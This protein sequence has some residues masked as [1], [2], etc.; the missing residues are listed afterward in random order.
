L[1]VVTLQGSP[2]TIV[3]CPKQGGEVDVAASTGSQ[4]TG[5]LQ[6]PRSDVLCSGDTC[7]MNNCGGHGTCNNVDGTCV[8]LPGFYGSTNY[9]CD[10]L[11]CPTAVG[12]TECSGN[13]KCNDNTGVCEDNQ[14]LAGCYVGWK[15]LACAVR[16]CPSFLSPACLDPTLPCE[17]SNRGAC[18]NGTCACA[19]GFVGSGCQYT[20][21]PFNAGDR[22]SANISQGECDINTGVC[23]CGDLTAGGS[24]VEAYFGGSS[25]QRVINGTRPVTE[26]HFIGE[27]NTSATS[28]SSQVYHAYSGVLFAKETVFFSLLIPNADF[29]VE[30]R[31]QSNNSAASMRLVASYQESGRPTPSFGDF[32]ASSTATVGE[33]AIELLPVSVSARSK[34]NRPGTLLI[35]AVVDKTSSATLSA[36]RDGCS[37]LKCG[38]G[39]CAD[40]ACVCDSG[41]SGTHCEQ[42]DCPGSPD[43]GNRGQCDSSACFGEHQSP[44]RTCRPVCACSNYFTGVACEQVNIDN[45]VAPVLRF[46]NFLTTVSP[47][48]QTSRRDNAVLLV[49]NTGE[50]AVISAVVEGTLDVNDYSTVAIIDPRDFANHVTGPLGVYMRLNF[51]GAPDAD[52]ILLG[53]E[54]NPPTLAMVGAMPVDFESAAWRNRQTVQHFVHKLT[55]DDSSTIY[56]ARIFNGRYGSARLPFSFYMEIASD[57]CPPALN[58]CS[59]H[60]SCNLQTY[61]CDCDYGFR[62]IDCGTAVLSLE[63]GFTELPPIAPGSWLYLQVPLIP[64]DVQLKLELIPSPGFS[65]PVLSAAFEESLSASSVGAV[66]AESAMFHFAN[67]TNGRSYQAP[68]QSLLLRRQF[69]DKVLLV[70]VLNH[71][72]ARA[73]LSATIA[74]SRFTS[75]RTRYCSP[76]DSNCMASACNGHGLYVSDPISCRC[77][78]GWNDVADCASPSFTSLQKL[79]LAAQQV[80]S[81]CTV[82]SEEMSLQDP[83]DIRLYIIPQALQKSTVL[84]LNVG[85]VNGNSSGGVPAMFVSS[86]LPRSIVDFT[87]IASSGSSNQTLSLGTT[88]SGVFVAAVLAQ[89]PGSFKLS[90]ARQVLPVSVPAKD[91]FKTQLA[92]W[93]LSTTAGTV[94]LTLGGALLLAFLLGCIFQCRGEKD[95]AYQLDMVGTAEGTALSSAK[96]QLQE[97]L[98]LH[99]EEAFSQQPA[100]RRLGPST[101]NLKASSKRNI[102]GASVPQVEQP[103]PVQGQL[104]VRE[105]KSLNT[106]SSPDRGLTRQPY[107]VGR[108]PLAASVAQHAVGATT[109]QV[110]P[111][112]IAF[113]TASFGPGVYGLGAYGPGAYGPV[114]S[115]YPSGSPP[116][117]AVPGQQALGMR[118]MPQPNFAQQHIIHPSTRMVTMPAR[119][120][121]AQARAAALVARANVA[122]PLGPPPSA[123]TVVQPEQEDSF[124]RE[125]PLRRQPHATPRQESHKIADL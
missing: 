25:C 98:A 99:G 100:I 72:S 109:G 47:G 36:R 13:G 60:G 75:V 73:P 21:C 7:A 62:G 10:R 63:D 28:N 39:R 112:T 96:H 70:G 34:F 4:Y 26:L 102:Q 105:S 61:S 95:A 91:S 15:G 108:A 56:I 76:D 48:I 9:T 120:P 22:C 54:N 107:P 123:A 114:A 74:F 78:M 38:F 118:M 37:T 46:S 79:L 59:S 125:N 64:S 2:Q 115:M 86:N 80:D 45:S 3:R 27:Q 20:D 42:P 84:Q 113:A 117:I 106:S 87:S 83:S 103:D 5:I 49:N 94:V 11:H 24:G 92:S 18:N 44:I 89:T 67:A 122:A 93:V 30:I 82:C 81:L 119:S 55:N 32:F 35:A 43:C 17:C 97:A 85:P 50:F 14:G 65:V 40:G 88:S 124:Q 33:L 110:Q 77:D 19:S 116:Y 66:T 1:I 52:G 71:A 53:M 57:I 41:W 111:R 6:C 23:T 29:S 31:F 12:G 51:T 69:R 121:A 101:R 16:G 90:A 58:G 8:C 68:Q 104:L